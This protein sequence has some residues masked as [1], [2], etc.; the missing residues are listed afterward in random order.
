MK[1]RRCEALVVPGS[2]ENAGNTI[3]NGIGYST[4][5]KSYGGQPVS[6]RFDGNHPEAFYVSKHV[7]NRKYMKISSLVSCCK[8][9]VVY[10]SKNPYSPVTSFAIDKLIKAFLLVLV[11]LSKGV[12]SV[13][14]YDDKHGQRF[15]NPDLRQNELDELRDALAL[16]KPSYRQE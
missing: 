12:L 5:R 15:F 1:C 4:C 3:C 13:V 10:R 7:A 2:Y 8:L 6:S 9:D 11:A 14:T 16:G